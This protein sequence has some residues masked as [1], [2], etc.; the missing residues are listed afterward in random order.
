MNAIKRLGLATAIFASLGASPIQA[1][2]LVRPPAYVWFYDNR[3]D[4]RDFPTNGVFPGDFA[5]NPLTAGIGAAGIFGSLP[6]HGHDYPPQAV[7][8]FQQH[9]NYCAR[10]YRSYDPASGTFIGRD[11]LRHRC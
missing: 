4:D 8:A 2:T 7:I 9:Q 1:Q 11:H 3:D 6:A 5:A 10:R